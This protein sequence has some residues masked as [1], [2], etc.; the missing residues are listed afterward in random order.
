MIRLFSELIKTTLEHLPDDAFFQTAT[1]KYKH[2]SEQCPS[3]GATGKLTPYGKYSRYLVY[4]NKGNNIESRIWP[5]RF[6]CLSCGKTHALLPSILIPYSPYS[7]RFILSVLIAYFE[8]T[9]T[10]VALCEEFGI[11]VSTLYA[12]KHRLLLHMDLLLG[13]IKSQAEPAPSLLLSLFES[14]QLW[15]RLSDFFSR[16]AFSFMQNKPAKATRPHPS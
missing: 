9:T 3:C 4:R 6:E 7:L 15:D 16:H 5:L 13:A 10:V 12:W 14:G 8:R 11:A 1:D 2:Y